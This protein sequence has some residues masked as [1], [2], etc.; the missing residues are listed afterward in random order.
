MQ[1][2]YTMS[3]KYTTLII[4]KHVYASGETQNKK[5]PSPW[6][7]SYRH[8][9]AKMKSHTFMFA[10]LHFQTKQQTAGSQCVEGFIYCLNEKP[11]NP[12]P[13]AKLKQ[14]NCSKD[15]QKL[16]KEIKNKEGMI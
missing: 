7:Q 6:C 15:K 2:W 5:G 10:S 8:E 12:C 3:V 9:K 11:T 16:K 1:T 14:E 13:V 4:T